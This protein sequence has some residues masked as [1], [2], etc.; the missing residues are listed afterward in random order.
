MADSL[1]IKGIEINKKDLIAG[2]KA[3]KIYKVSNAKLS[4]VKLKKLLDDKLKEIE[5]QYQCPKCDSTITDCEICPYCGQVFSDED[6][7]ETTSSLT[8]DTSE[9]DR[10]LRKLP[11]DVIREAHNNVIKI[12]KEIAR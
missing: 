9:I 3:L 12:E 2:L 1:K 5:A 7:E 4:L 11:R 8:E 10:I 6:E